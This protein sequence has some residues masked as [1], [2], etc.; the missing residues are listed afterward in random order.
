MPKRINFT[1]L[2]NTLKYYYISLHDL[3]YTVNNYLF[4]LFG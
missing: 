2:F 3:E 4:D 1:T